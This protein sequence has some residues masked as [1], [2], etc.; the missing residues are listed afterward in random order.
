MP[1]N[2]IQYYKYNDEFRDH[3][4]G[5]EFCEH[6]IREIIKDYTKESLFRTFSVFAQSIGLG[7]DYESILIYQQQQFNIHVNRGLVLIHRQSVCVIQQF[8]FDSKDEQFGERTDVLIRDL[9]LLLLCANQLTDIVESETMQIKKSRGKRLFFT[10][11]KSIHFTNNK[12]DLQAGFRLFREYYQKMIS[13]NRELYNEVIKKEFGFG[14]SEYIKILDL[15][16]ERNYPEIF[17]LFDKFAVIDFEKTFS[18]WNDRNPKFSIPKEI[19]FIQKYPLIKINGQYLVTDLHSV[20]SSLFK[21]LYR[22]LLEYD[23]IT[24]KG[25]FGKHIIEPTII[26]L[27]SEIFVDDNVVP[28]KVGSKNREYGDFGLLL[29]DS[30]FLFEIKSSLL[31]EPSIY[32]DKYDV[33]MKIFNDKFVNKEGIKQQVKKIQLIEDNFEHFCSL[34]KITTDKKYIIY[35]ILVSFDESLMSFCCNWYLSM[36][37]EVLKRICKL[38]LSNISL[39]N[40]HSTITFNEMYRM[41]YVNKSPSD[42]LKLLKRYSDDVNK[43][44]ISFSFYLQDFNAFTISKTN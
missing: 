4:V 32:T 16:E 43:N 33:F 5:R 28:L 17:K 21:N 24:F 3:N 27:I 22:V 6:T 42:R 19:P 20:F 18:A 13:L 14:I 15:I 38:N 31:N 36:R 7:N 39:A 34:G 26:E 37:F 2:V 25:D 29:D 11:I 40:C 8:L 23:N 10:N 41:R 35:P 30:I 44:P 9:F 1:R 12:D